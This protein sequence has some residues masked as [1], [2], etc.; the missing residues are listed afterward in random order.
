MFHDQ[1]EQILDTFTDRYLLWECKVR[2]RFKIVFV[3]G[4]PWQMQPKASEDLA[5]AFRRGVIDAGGFHFPLWKTGRPAPR[6]ICTASTRN[7]N[8]D[9]DPAARQPRLSAPPATAVGMG[10][11]LPKEK[12]YGGTG[13]FKFRT[14][15]RTV[16]IKSFVNTMA[17]VVELYW[18]SGTDQSALPQLLAD[19]LPPRIVSTYY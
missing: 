15:D 10:T 16:K 13:D 4:G 11:I 14:S 1:E 6:A 18:L 7:V 9:E 5:T 12:I 17:A 19:T 3:N 2:L 8:L